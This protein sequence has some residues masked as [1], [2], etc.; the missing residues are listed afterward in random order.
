MAVLS[1]GF[2]IKLCPTNY[3]LGKRKQQVYA[4]KTQTISSLGKLLVPWT[5]LMYAEL[6]TCFPFQMLS[7]Y[8]PEL[9]LQTSQWFLHFILAAGFSKFFFKQLVTLR[10]TEVTHYAGNVSLLHSPLSMLFFLTSMPFPAC[11]VMLNADLALPV[12]LCGILL[13]QYLLWLMYINSDFLLFHLCP[14]SSSFNF[15]YHCTAA[16]DFYVWSLWL[17]FHYC[18]WPRSYLTEVISKKFCVVH[19][20]IYRPAWWLDP[21]L[22]I[23][24]FLLIL[25]ILLWVAKGRFLL[26]YYLNCFLVL[27]VTALLVWF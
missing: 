1:A 13:I 26:W 5:I 8:Y 23:C 6:A 17:Y 27:P 16:V 3:I 19:F 7:F 12:V 14:N 9:T 11:I 2:I 4:G 22:L 18:F 21:H 25:P 24:I 20:C 15:A 10:K